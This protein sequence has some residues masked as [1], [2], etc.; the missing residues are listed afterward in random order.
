MN[1]SWIGDTCFRV[2]TKEGIVV[3]DPFT[4][5]EKGVTMPKTECAIL[6]AS[7]RTPQT[8]QIKGEPFII[9][10][11]GEYSIGG[12]DVKAVPV[13]LDDEEGKKEGRGLAFVL[14]VEDV[15]LCHLGRIGTSLVNGEIEAIGDVDVLLTPIGCAPLTTIEVAKKNIQTI[16]PRMV[17][18]YV[19]LDC[20][21]K[22]KEDLFDKFGHE[23][24]VSADDAQEKIA[25]TAASLPE[26]EMV[27]VLL[28]PVVG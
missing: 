17:V 22:E 23:M 12:L 9:D 6:L 5:E 4:K 11:P 14:R 15:T 19:T 2:Q 8:E 3:I 13:W 20:S 10:A 18:P 24:G 27:V 7:N 28:K 26:E 25:V 21:S 16:E 1:I